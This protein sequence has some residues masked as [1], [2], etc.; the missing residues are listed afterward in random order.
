[1]NKKKLL[2]LSSL[3]LFLT[4]ALMIMLLTVSMGT[5]PENVNAQGGESNRVRLHLGG[6]AL[7]CDGETGCWLLN[8]NGQFLFDVAQNVIDENLGTACSDQSAPYLEVGEGTFGTVSFQFQC[9]DGRPPHI[10]F[11]GVDEHGKRNCTA[12]YPN[13]LLMVD[14]TPRQNLATG[15]PNP[16]ATNTNTAVNTSTSTNTP[17][18]TSTSTNTPTDT[19][20]S[21]NTPTDTPTNTPTFTPTETLIIV[22]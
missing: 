20:T 5:S 22:D 8:S 12:I 2:G 14:P 17:V 21:T 7:F 19:S 15:T 10:I 13:G 9:Y 16:L 18:D 1:M 3:A 6:D 4:V 11:C